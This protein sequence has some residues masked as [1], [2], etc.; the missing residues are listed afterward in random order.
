MQVRD[1][2]VDGTKSMVGSA[3][4]ANR[5]RHIDA[6]VKRTYGWLCPFQDYTS[7]RYFN[8][9]RRIELVH[10]KVLGNHWIV[11]PGKRKEKK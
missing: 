11:E 8:T 7:N 5:I 2:F 10:E 4:G 6:K 1:G 9:K 3:W